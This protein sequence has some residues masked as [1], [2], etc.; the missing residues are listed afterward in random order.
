MTDTWAVYSIDGDVLHTMEKVSEGHTWAYRNDVTLF[1]VGPYP[2]ADRPMLQHTTFCDRCDGSGFRPD[3]YRLLPFVD[4][5][6]VTRGNV[7]DCSIPW[8]APQECHFCSGF[9]RVTKAR[10][11][12]KS[13]AHF[14]KHL[15]TGVECSFCCGSG[16]TIRVAVLD[17]CRSCNG[18]GQQLTW[19]PSR[20]I[21]PPSVDYC[22][23]APR[24]FLEAWIT[25]VTIIVDRSERPMTW[26]ESFLG[27][28]GLYSVTD[29]GTAWDS[30][31][32][33][34]IQS[35]YES[36]TEGYTQYTKLLDPITRRFADAI[37]IEVMR[38]GYTP[39][40]IIDGRVSQS[41]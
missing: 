37:V 26:A 21:L 27:S 30:D 12:Y 28:F 31:D 1:T 35:F 4:D 14:E 18:Q 32:G 39:F 15:S 38:N 5:D 16:Q 29:Y 7:L 9:G 40:A 34:V 11:A 6:V 19:D 33:H 36:I 8:D 41:A 23:S 20:P 24:Q 13:R 3:A 2:D 17:T 22:D 25:S 10:S